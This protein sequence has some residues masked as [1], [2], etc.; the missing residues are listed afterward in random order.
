MAKVIT[1]AV[2]QPIYY[3]IGQDQTTGKMLYRRAPFDA[4]LINGA[5]HVQPSIGGATDSA[6]LALGINTAEDQSMWRGDI[7]GYELLE[8]IVLNEC[9]MGDGSDNWIGLHAISNI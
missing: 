8:P 9:Q 5:I 3:Q 2:T 7:G 6:L 1:N 4:V